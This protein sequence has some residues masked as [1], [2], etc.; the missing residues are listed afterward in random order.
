M[1]ISARCDFAYVR[2]LLATCV[3]NASCYRVV[4]R[5][6]LSSELHHDKSVI[7]LVS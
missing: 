2:W 5:V 3:R 1:L 7:G 6:S 4:V